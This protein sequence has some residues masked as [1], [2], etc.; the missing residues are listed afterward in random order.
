MSLYLWIGFFI[1]LVLALGVDLYL[2]NK[3]GGHIS[4]RLSLI[5]T[6]VWGAL[7]MLFAV[8]VYYYKGPAS[9]YEFVAGYLVE[10]SLSIDN[11][12]VFVLLFR[13]FKVPANAQHKVLFLGIIGAI[14]MRL[15]MIVAGVYLVQKFEWIFYVFGLMLLYGAYKITTSKEDVEGAED[16]F[17]INFLSKMFSI[18]KEYHGQKFWIIQNGKRVF[19]PLFVVLILI[20][21]TDLVFAID[22]I[23][24]ILAI[25]RDT[26]IVFTSNIFAIL[27]LRA[28]YFSIAGLVDQFK[29]L[30]YGL[31]I[32]LAY[33][34]V[35]MM[36][37]VH[38]IHIP[39]IFSLC[40]IAVSMIGAIAASMVEYHIN[41]KIKPNS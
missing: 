3:K 10:L 12:F 18:Y 17:I 33:V 28:L 34:G 32:I 8:F 16:N 13:Y 38:V 41:K 24:A 22:S 11:V 26:F 2:F 19:T 1:F 40:V 29:Y 35:K 6:G 25:T 31:G 5:E 39:T 14:V 30:K 7:A 9:M 36:L 27:G 23:P 20:E 15:L 4:T 21:K 37:M